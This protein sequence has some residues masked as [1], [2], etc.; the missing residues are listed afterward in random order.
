MSIP[1]GTSKDNATKYLLTLQILFDHLKHHRSDAQSSEAQETTVYAF[2]RPGTAAFGA[3]LNANSVH[4]FVGLDGNV[5]DRANFLV[6]ARY[7]HIL[8]QALKLGIRVA[9]L[10]DM[11][12]RNTK[13]SI[14]LIP[15]SESPST[16]QG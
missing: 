15:A 4:C 16:N 3:Y 5:G 9:V 7:V 13:V 2:T 10:N 6:Q 14:P 1:A 8:Y 12:I 11:E